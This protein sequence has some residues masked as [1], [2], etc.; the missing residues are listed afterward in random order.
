LAE[1]AKRR[2]LSVSEHS[3]ALPF[4]AKGDLPGLRESLLA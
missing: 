2:G 4:D 3:L 1:E